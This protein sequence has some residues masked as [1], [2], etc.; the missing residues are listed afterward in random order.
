[1][2]VIRVRTERRAST[3]LT[4]TDAPAE[5][6]TMGQTAREV[7]LSPSSV[8]FN[9]SACR[10]PQVYG[11]T[12]GNMGGVSIIHTGPALST[13]ECWSR[14]CGGSPISAVKSNGKSN[15]MWNRSRL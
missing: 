7:R 2:R 10:V 14:C 12:V 3:E 6:A 5:A 11:R 9:P 15:D 4:A 8:V 13:L 1:M